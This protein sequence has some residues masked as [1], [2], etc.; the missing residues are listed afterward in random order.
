MLSTLVALAVLSPAPL[1]P[2]PIAPSRPRDIWAFRSVLDRR[3]RMLTLALH[4]DLWVAYDATNCGLYKVWKGGVKFDGAVYT[5]AHGPQPTSQ[6]ELI[7]AGIVDEPVWLYLPP[8]RDGSVAARPVRPEFKGYRFRDGGITLQYRFRPEPNREVWIFETPEVR[9]SEDR[10][11]LERAFRFQGLRRGEGMALRTANPQRGEMFFGGSAGPDEAPVGAFHRVGGDGV[12]LGPEPLNLVLSRQGALYASAAGGAAA[13]APVAQDPA[14]APKIPGAAMRVYWIG[15]NMR[16]IPRLLAAQSPNFSVVIPNVDLRGHAAF[17]MPDEQKDHFFV[18]I[19]GYLNVDRDGEYEFRLFSDDGSRFRIRDE[20]VIDRDGLHSENPPKTGK[21]RLTRGAHPFEIEY[22][23]NTVDE[24]LRLEWKTP[25][26]TA[27]VVVPPEAFSTPDGEV[28]VTAPGRKAIY[29]P[30]GRRRPGDG[31]PLVDVHPSFDLATV[32]PA[33][34]R[35]RVGGMDFLPDGRLVVCTWDSDGAVYVLGGVDR[36][37]PNAISVKRVAAGLAEPLG[38]KVVDGQ[39]YVLQ[40]QELTLLRDH[41]G[42]GVM[43]EYHAVANGWGVTPNF[44]EFAFGLE[45][46]RGH[47]YA[48]LAIAIDPGGASTK[49]QNPDRGKVIEITRNGDYRFVADGLRTPNGIGR[50]FRNGIFITDNQGDW[51]PSSKL[52]HLTPG[53]FFGSHAVVPAA[54]RGKTEKPPVA[55]LPQGEIGNSPSQP[56][57][58][59]VGPFRDQMIHGDVTHGGLKRVFVEEV[60]GQLQGCVFRFTQGLEAGVNRIVWGPDGALY[61]GGIGSAGNWGQEG[62]ERFG[63]QRLRYNGKS[64]FEMLAVRAMSNGMEIELTEPLAPGAGESLGDYLVRSW[65]YMPTEEYGG[66]KVDE[67]GHAVTGLAV[68]R[69]RRRVFLEIPG[70]EAGRVVYVKLHRGLSSASGR[71][72]WSTEGWYTLNR[73]PVNRQ[74]R[75]TVAQRSPNTLSPEE[76]RQGFRLLFDGKTLDGWRG[77]RRTEAPSGWRAVDGELRFEPGRN[78]GDLATREQFGDFEL[79]IDW[80][81]S[82]GGNSGIFYRATEDHST[83]WITGPEYQILDDDLHPDGRSPLTSAASVYGLYPPTRD[84]VREAGQWNETRIVVRGDRVEHWLN[85]VKVVEYVLNS[86][87]WR[88]RV[89]KSKFAGMKEYGQRKKGHIVLQDHGD[90]VAYRNIRIRE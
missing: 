39:I 14:E 22:F 84:V 11:V 10:L 64:T 85:G 56:A 80:R 66:P 41:D 48:A 72:L 29:D 59:N 20:V 34:F 51:L 3:A 4:E 76:A 60:D 77:W 26:S 52:L 23:E 33:A 71:E 28:R 86:E 54:T 87:E 7:Q 2:A 70:L 31:Q 63:L 57:R 65:K 35:P 27:F 46:D 25:G 16:E 88:D 53:A 83:P 45:Y 40:K 74:G 17:G 89:A 42:D 32:R 9:E 43:D 24:V 13:P 55:W 58:L 79:R 6:G 38:L 12:I 62:K 78:G 37:R 21:F 47:F 1:D 5:T 30:A 49:N 18:R 73:V 44:H 69:D 67:R 90:V 75:A 61:V 81:V 82:P 68:S 19:T 36:E 8:T 50:G 15:A